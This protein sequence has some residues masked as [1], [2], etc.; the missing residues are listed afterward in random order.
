[1]DPVI[2]V[3]LERIACGKPPYHLVHPA[4]HY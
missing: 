2:A 3:N 1:M 4:R